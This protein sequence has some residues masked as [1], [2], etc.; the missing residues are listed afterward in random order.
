MNITRNKRLLDAKTKASILA[1]LRRQPALE[2]LVFGL[3]RQT[4]WQ[5]CCHIVGMWWHHGV[6]FQQVF[7]AC[8]HGP[9]TFNSV[10]LSYE[11]GTNSRLMAFVGEDFCGHGITEA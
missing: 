4:F 8:K 3:L 11:T 9:V 5:Q 6:K 2:R 7:S 1:R 10:L